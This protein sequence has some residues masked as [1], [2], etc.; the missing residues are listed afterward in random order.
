MKKLIV[1]ALTATI[2]WQVKA[3]DAVWL[4]DLPRA[5][6]QAR[7]ENKI[8]LMDF[9]GSDWCPDCIQLKKKVFDTEKFQAYAATHA[10]LV[11]VDFPDKKDQSDDLK[12]ANAKLKEKY[13]VEGF[14]TLIVLDSSGKEIGRQ[15][16]Y[17]GSDPKAFIETLEKFTAAK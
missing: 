14:P 10:V 7:A 6:A 2:L 9:S 11:D 1:T 13:N 8:V 4:T 5:Q 3:A 16:G 12:K 15:S 17:D